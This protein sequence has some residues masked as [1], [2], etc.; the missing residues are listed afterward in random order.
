MSP[1]DAGAP[2][3][4][5]IPPPLPNAQRFG[6]RWEAPSRGLYAALGIAAFIALLMTLPGVLAPQAAGIQGDGGLLALRQSSATMADKLAQAQAALGSANCNPDGSF[7]TPAGVGQLPP[8]P[9][10]T[11]PQDAIAQGDKRRV[12]QLSAQSVVFVLTCTDQHGIDEMHKDDKENAK[13]QECPFNSAASKGN[14]AGSTKLFLAAS[15]SGF[16]IGRN[17]IVTNQHVVDGS[18]AVFVTNRFLGAA[19]EGRVLVE[20]IPTTLGKPDF[21][22]IHVEEDHTPPIIPLSDHVDI[23]EDVV[24]AGFPASYLK[25]RWKSTAAAKAEVRTS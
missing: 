10:P 22:I 15:G 1:I 24:S 5:P 21:A 14:E 19:E 25:L 7:T 3:S 13:P 4:Q 11:K 9:I 2:S 18:K 12:V 8:Q 17:T 6:R 16:F 23:L 20:K